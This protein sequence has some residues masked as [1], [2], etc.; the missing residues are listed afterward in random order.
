MACPQFVGYA[1]PDLCPSTPIHYQPGYTICL[2]YHCFPRAE[3]KQLAVRI[4]IGHQG[5]QHPSMCG[6]KSN[7]GS[8]TFLTDVYVAG[9][10]VCLFRVCTALLPPPGG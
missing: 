8:D 9:V 6:E 2:H 7:R 5:S 1:R 10:I 3:P 4:K